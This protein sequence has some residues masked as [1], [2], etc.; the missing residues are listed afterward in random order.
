MELLAPNSAVLSTIRTGEDTG[1]TPYALLG[2]SGWTDRTPND[3]TTL[4]GL[5]QEQR[6]QSPYYQNAM[7]WSKNEKYAS[8][9]FAINSVLLPHIDTDADDGDQESCDRVIL[10]AK[11]YALEKVSLSKED[12]ARLEMINQKMDLKYPRYSD[13]DWELLDEAKT[14]LDELSGI[15]RAER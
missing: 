3:S 11:K 15:S 6:P 14:L 4:E 12:N 1:Q 2:H 13:K 9:S 7:D 10:L 8:G 5:S